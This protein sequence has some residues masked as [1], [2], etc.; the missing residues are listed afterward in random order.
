[1][2]NI[3]TSLIDAIATRKRNIAAG[4]KDSMHIALVVEGGGMRGVAAGGMVS[5][6]EDLGLT[7]V[8]DS[9]HGS[10]AGAAAAAYFAVGKANLGTRLYYEDLNDGRFISRFGPI[11][12]RPILDTSFLVDYAMV[13]KKPFDFL[14]L[15][16]GR[17]RLF[18]VTT[19][20]DRGTSYI[21]NDFRDYSHYRQIMKA[22]ITLPLIAGRAAKVD[23]RRLLDGGLLQQ[24]ALKSASDAG[25]TH[26]LAL[27]T[28]GEHELRRPPATLKT[29]VESWVLQMMYGGKTGDLYFNRNTTINAQ[30]DQIE[31]GSTETGAS[32]SAIGLPKG[33]DY[34]HR[35][36]TDAGLLKKAAMD[37]YSYTK[38]GLTG[39][40]G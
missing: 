2:L 22:S 29:R 35:L 11:S 40:G 4:T 20:I 38:D 32:V 21:A 15:Q 12:G 19:D 33:M 3:S 24:I 16:N 27:M 18:V 28:R 23:N 17:P 39:V 13:E 1:M 36:T 25:A 10:S 26:I 31:Q 5:A 7:A 14:T 34:I 9:V 37:A 30:I 8:F 6:L